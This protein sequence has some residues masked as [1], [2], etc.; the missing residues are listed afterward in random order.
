MAR[1]RF[2]TGFCPLRPRFYW[3]HC[4]ARLEMQAIRITPQLFY[5]HLRDFSPEQLARA[6][7]IRSPPRLLMVES[8]AMRHA[9]SFESVSLVIALAS[10]LASVAA[11]LIAKS[12]LSQAKQV[13]DRDE[14]DWRQ[15]KWADMYLKADETYDGLDRFRVLSDS[16]DTEERE[17]EW[18]DLMRLIRGAHAMA[19]VFP[20]NP[21]VDAFLSCT[22]V[23]KDQ[24]TVSKDRLSKVFDAV[25]LIRER[26]R[27]NRRV[28]EN[29]QVG[30]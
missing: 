7:T 6:E 30:T 9:I 1:V 28:L 26:A 5:A 23:F 3:T 21:A 17:R 11:T 13:A 29:D 19:V 4:N 10:L 16:W 20:E 18:N 25:E 15:R 14:R 12:S 8:V 27:V 2:R 24:T 22:K